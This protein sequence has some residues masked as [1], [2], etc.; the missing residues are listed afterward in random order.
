MKLNIIYTFLLISNSFFT[1]IKSEDSSFSLLDMNFSTIDDNKL[2][3]FNND[4]EFSKDKQDII[5]IQQKM[6]KVA[7]LNI[8]TKVIKESKSDIKNQIKSAK[9]QNKNNF[10]KFIHDMTNTCINI[11]KEKEVKQIL[12]IEN[13]ENKN[14]PFGKKKIQFDEHLARFIEDNEIFKKI[15]EIIELKKQ[16]KKMIINTTCIAI[17]VLIIFYMCYIIRKIKKG[18]NDFDNKD[19]K[20][21]KSGN[22]K[23]GKKI[24]KEN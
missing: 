3:S 8:I 4:F 17:I 15:E 6:K 21:K 24:E 14:F 19:K 16:R 20:E 18:K 2:K 12:N 22:K 5:S 11:I 9:A 1:Y 10:N 7:C 13:F 23:K